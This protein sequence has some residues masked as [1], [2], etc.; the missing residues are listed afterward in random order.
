MPFVFRVNVTGAQK[1]SQE[2]AALGPKGIL[3][4][5]E[6]LAAAAARMVT[7]A[8]E[9]SPVEEGDLHDRIKATVPRA[10][11]DGMVTVNVMAER[12]VIQHEDLTQNH[13]HG[14]G[15]K[16]IER[17]VHAM[18]PDIPAALLAGMRKS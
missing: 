13:P 7:R 14:G 15:P 6:V 2:L 12:A 17:P 9:L 5:K 11:R 1:I 3:V 8:R 16:F 10:T 18:A 4:A